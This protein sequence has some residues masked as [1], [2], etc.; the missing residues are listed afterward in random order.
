MFVLW[1]ICYLLKCCKVLIACTLLL[2]FFSSFWRPMW[3]IWPRTCLRFVVYLVFDVVL[4]VFVAA[5]VVVVVVKG[6]ILN[7][8]YCSCWMCC[9]SVNYYTA[10]LLLCWVGINYIWQP[11]GQV[12]INVCLSVCL[13]VLAGL[14]VCLSVCPPIYLRFS[15]VFT[16]SVFIWLSD[17]LCWHFV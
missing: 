12:F 4:S 7:I 13:S 15:F 2:P 9:Q 5:A 8:S 17:H 11:R 16:F 6:L 3:H 14:S 1:H 10:G